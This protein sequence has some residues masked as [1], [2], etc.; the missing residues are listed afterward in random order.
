MAALGERTGFQLMRDFSALVASFFLFHFILGAFIIFG[1]LIVPQGYEY[2]LV[3]IAFALSGPMVGMLCGILVPSG[4]NKIL[5]LLIFITSV[6]AFILFDFSFIYGRFNFP[7][8]LIGLL[9]SVYFT[10]RGYKW[11]AKN[12]KIKWL[13]S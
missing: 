7:L 2:H 4:S 11:S 9:F 10:A 5:A 1:S 3:P 6:A 8:L 13:K 12:I